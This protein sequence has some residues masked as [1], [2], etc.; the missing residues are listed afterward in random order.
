[1]RKLGYYPVEIVPAILAEDEKSFFSL[2][3]T[4]LK[5]AR[6]LQFDF[7]DGKFVPSK[8][9]PVAILKELAKKFDLANV[10]LEAHLMVFN[11]ENYASE[12]VGNGIRTIIFHV[13]AVDSPKE[14]SLFFKSKGIEVGI[15]LNPETPNESIEKLIDIVDFVMFMTV[16]PGFYGSPLEVDVLK[17]IKDFALNYPHVLIAVDGGVKIDNIDLFISA[18]A[19]RIC[20]G[21]AIMKAENPKVAY[22]RFLE[23]VSG[24]VI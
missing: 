3:K 15:A 18:G 10:I 22:N 13:E 9:V 11:P 20:I 5:F 14:T 7:M 12:L 2:V 6:R 16:K 24:K 19:R 1:M 17:K 8:S 23:K 21:S 4:A